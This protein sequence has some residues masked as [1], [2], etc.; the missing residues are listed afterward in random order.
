MQFS[1][2]SQSPETTFTVR[3]DES[4]AVS[5]ARHLSHNIGQMRNCLSEKFC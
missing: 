2:S 3:D 4:A 5:S 1:P